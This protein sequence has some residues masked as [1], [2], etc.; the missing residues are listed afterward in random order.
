MRELLG[1][2]DGKRLR[3]FATVER[4]G[5]KRGWRG[6]SVDTILL[7]NVCLGDEVV[8]DH[9]WFTDGKWSVGL[10]IGDVFSFEAR[11]STYVKGY[12]GRLAEQRSRAWS[13]SD[14]HLERPTKIRI[15]TVSPQPA[16]EGTP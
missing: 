9:L 16:P 8:C 3:F 1:R 12:Q 4:Y 15:E 10:G 6:R 11:V 13:E 14:Y 7:R 2:H 5:S